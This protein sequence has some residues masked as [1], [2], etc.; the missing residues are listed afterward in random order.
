ML[1]SGEDIL[2]E[3]HLETRE[4]EGGVDKEVMG[5]LILLKK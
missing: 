4:E 1:R 5:Y 2:K 3:L